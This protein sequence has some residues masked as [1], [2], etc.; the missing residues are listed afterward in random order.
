M[1][2]VTIHNIISLQ[3]TTTHISSCL[4]PCTVHTVKNRLTTSLPTTTYIALMQLAA[5]ADVFC[6]S[7]HV[8]VIVMELCHGSE[9][10][11]LHGKSVGYDLTVLY[12]GW[13]QLILLNHTVKL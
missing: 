1:L 7:S 10:V 8:H 13:K 3:N 6:N 5:V 4:Q 2:S 11:I 9:S 12:I